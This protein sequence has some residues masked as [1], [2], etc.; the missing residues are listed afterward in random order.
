MPIP[1]PVLLHEC[2]VVD[3]YHEGSVYRISLA[4]Q[5]QSGAGMPFQFA[6]PLWK[7]N[8][9]ICDYHLNPPA[10]QIPPDPLPEGWQPPDYRPAVASAAGL[11][12][13]LVWDGVIGE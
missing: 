4:L 6:D 8:A 5:P 12:V 3:I 9:W 7:K 11:P 10:Y 2:E 13:R 1:E